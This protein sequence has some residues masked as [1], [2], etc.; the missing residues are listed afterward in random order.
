MW[1]DGENDLGACRFP[2]APLV[3]DCARTVVQRLYEAISSSSCKRSFLSAPM[4]SAATRGGPCKEAG[5]LDR[6]D[7]GAL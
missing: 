1:P 5:D 2:S 3:A 7:V 4:S 6:G